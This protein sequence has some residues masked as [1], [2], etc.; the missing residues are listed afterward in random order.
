MKKWIC[1]LLSAVL[2]LSGTFASAAGLD[3]LTD[4]SLLTY[5]ATQEIS[6]EFEI[7]PELLEELTYTLSESEFGA[8]FDLPLMLE[9]ILNQKQTAKV[10]VKIRE[11]FKR[12]EM[13][14]ETEARKDV[15]INSNL[16]VQ[17]QGRTGIWLDMDLTDA[18]NPKLLV[19]S[20]SPT[21]PKYMV[22]DV[23][24]ILEVAGS[25]EDKQLVSGLLQMIYNQ[26]A[27]QK[28]MQRNRELIE[29]YATVD[30]AYRSC[31]VHF[32]SENFSRYISELYCEVVDWFVPLEV[33]TPAEADE[34]KIQT[35]TIAPQISLLGEDGYT[36]QVSFNGAKAVQKV[37]TQMDVDICL[38][39]IFSVL[40]PTGESWVLDGEGRIAAT[41]CEEMKLNAWGKSVSVKYPMLTAENSVSYSDLLAQQ[42]AAEEEEIDYPYYYISVAT[43]ALPMIDGQYYVPLR[44]TFEAAYDDQF[45]IDFTD[46]GTITITSP[47]FDTITTRIGAT[48]ATVNGEEI[49]VG[50]VILHAG[51]TT[52]VNRRFFERIFGW[53]LVYLGYDLPWSEYYYDFITK[54]LD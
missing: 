49:Q 9:G 7:A 36:M 8:M 28:L 2:L 21:A 39:D 53:Q 31:T 54:T 33:I 25:E 38:R 34:I 42:M 48:T 32:D 35:L 46:D 47:W 18:A 19:I 45:E 50:E 26:E 5:S 11:D 51:H 1:I 41:V 24:A 22:I 27:M 12:I 14:L 17:V 40:D 16:D 30:V 23:F 20:S 43:L 37:T 13:S 15:C 10:A 44:A 52:Y 4:N 29:Q 6:T 3:F